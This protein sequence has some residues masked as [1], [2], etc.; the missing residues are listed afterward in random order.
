LW[1][2]TTDFDGFFEAMVVAIE[3]HITLAWHTGAKDCGVLPDELTRDERIRLQQSINYEKQWITGLGLTIEEN[4]R[5]NGG[6]LGPLFNRIEVWIG[7]WEG[8]RDEARAMACRDKK[9]KWVLGPTEESCRSCLSLNGKVK[10]ASWWAEMGILP[11]VHNA[12]YL[13]CGGWRC[14]CE[15]VPTNERASPGP[16]P[17]LP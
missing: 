7:R 6:K 9:L 2:D 8:T 1:T 13:E 10:R 3:R 12:P 16:M 14:L 11:R 15:L 5:A 4:S 17:G